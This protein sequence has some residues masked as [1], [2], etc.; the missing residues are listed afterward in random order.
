MA[1][2]LATSEADF[3]ID[4]MALPPAC[5]SVAGGSEGGPAH[6]GAEAPAALAG[7]CG[8]AA[9]PG[10]VPSDVQLLA[11]ELAAVEAEGSLGG[12]GRGPVFPQRRVRALQEYSEERRVRDAWGGVASSPGSGEV[13]LRPAESEAAAAGIAEALARRVVLAAA[14]AAE[15]A[16][17]DEAA[18]K[19]VATG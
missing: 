13:T 16:V 19:V 3:A 18:K 10:G 15:A 1:A 12:S 5:G 17:V 7:A 9:T 2:R 14:R 8:D 11:A 4:E 6:S